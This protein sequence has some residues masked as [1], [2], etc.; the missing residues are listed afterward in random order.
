MEHLDTH[1]NEVHIK[2]ND[3]QPE[4]IEHH[5]DL[6]NDQTNDQSND[7]TNEPTKKKRSKKPP[8]KPQFNGICNKCAKVFRNETTYTE[9]MKYQ[10][11]TTATTTTYCKICDLTLNNRDDYEKHLVSLTHIDKIQSNFGY[12][13][14]I[15]I[16]ETPAI[17]IIDPYLTSD[18]I[19]NINKKTL[20]TN[21]TINFKNN[22]SQTVNLVALPKVKKQS[23]NDNISDPN[24]QNQ[25]NQQN[26]TT[27]QQKQN[28][29]NPCQSN[30]TPNQVT[31]NHTVNKP[32]TQSTMSTRIVDAT[33]RQ[34]K[35][36]T[37]LEGIQDSSKCA[38]K[39][40]ELLDNK[41]HIDD[42]KNLQSLIKQ[43]AIITNQMKEIYITTIEKFTMALIK[44][45]TKGTTLYKEKDIAT[46]VMNL[47]S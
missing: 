35:I 11:C 42:Y 3:N 5:I 7:Q 2:N 13:E 4:S 28:N 47:T 20:G 43:S 45:K 15:E 32:V 25:Q 19:A 33:Q 29:N 40:L 18:D 41:L 39:L 17:N 22:R 8:A 24:E 1:L 44:L 12:I 26:L 27:Q 36:I 23:V 14:P 10:K 21:F 34:K 9:H 38:S 16:N 30:P 31:Q 37:F 46:L 6:T